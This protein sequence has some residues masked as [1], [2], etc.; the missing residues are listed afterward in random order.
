[1]VGLTAP[2]AVLVGPQVEASP[3]AVHGVRV[4]ESPQEYSRRAAPLDQRLKL[5]YPLLERVA[6]YFG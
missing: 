2:S 3:S 5:N 1:M 4:Y 6:Q